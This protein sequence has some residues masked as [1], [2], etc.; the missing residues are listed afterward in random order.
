MSTGIEIT[1]FLVCPTMLGQHLKKARVERGLRQRDV[2]KA[3]Q[4]DSMSIV[5]WEN[6]R[7]Q[8]GARFVPRIIQWLGY[9][10]LLKPTQPR[11]VDSC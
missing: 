11:V 4:I 6:D 9:D 8:V 2:A 7:T 5:N 10:P 1:D 3:L